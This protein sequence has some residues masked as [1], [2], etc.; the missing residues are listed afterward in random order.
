MFGGRLIRI[1]GSSVPL[2]I[3]C[4]LLFHSLLV[5]LLSKNQ[6]LFY[7]LKFARVIV[8]YLGVLTLSLLYRKKYGPDFIY[9]I[10]EHVFW[11]VAFHA[12]IMVL[13]YTSSSFAA[14]VNQIS[15][16]PPWKIYRS[17]GL[18]VSYTTLNV[19][20]GM[21]LLIA[22]TLHH[23][24]RSKV[25]TFFFL[26]AVIVI[27][28]SMLFAGR[29]AAYLMYSFSFLAVLLGWRRF[30]IKWKPILVL[31]GMFLLMQAFP[32]ADNNEAFKK[33]RSVTLPTLVEP[34]QEYVQTGIIW[35]TYGGR[36]AE[37]IFKTMY[38]LP[39]DD[40]TILFGSSTSGRGD[41][42]VASDVG[43]IL[44]IFGIGIFGLAGVIGFYVYLLFLGVKWRQYDFWIAFLTV[45]LALALLL[46][47][48]KEQTLLTR[49]AFTL[50]AF[51]L[52]SWYIKQAD[53]RSA[54]KIIRVQS[55]NY[56]E[57]NLSAV[58][59]SSRD[60]KI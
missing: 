59:P 12:A 41:V 7:P 49:H 55:L 38:F 42:Y 34:V 3:F 23:R 6:E 2:G 25:K 24:F 58:I 54:K 14:L 16:Y 27:L 11:A 18:T 33:F 9:K 47:N 19:V 17:T 43:Y 50:S 5:S 39:K 48:F 36:T 32:T 31:A 22:I 21:G 60:N 28:V 52:C 13:Q 46:L 35:N 40:A 45:M 15:G 20:Q 26:P 37:K 56:H 30:L 57:R 1:E 51:L 53:Y 10:L 29:T 4:W 8:N 44:L